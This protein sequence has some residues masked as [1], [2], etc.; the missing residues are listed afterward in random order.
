MRHRDDRHVDAGEGA[1]L[2]REHAARVDH[3]P[4]LDRAPVGLDAGHLA[5]L[6]R[7]P[8]DARARVDLGAAA[9]RAL[10]EREGELARVDVA[11]AR[12]V[13]GA[14]DAVGRHR[15]EEL[16][17]L[18]RRDELERQAER[19]RP[20]GLARDLLQ[21]LGRGGEPQ[22]ADLA[23]AG[24]EADLRLERAVELDRAHHHPRQRERAAQLADEPGGVERRAARQVGPLD[25]DDVVPAEPRQPVEDRAAADATADHDRARARS[26]SST[27]VD[28]IT[29]RV[30]SAR[31]RSRA[32]STGGAVG[33]EADA[34]HEQ[35]RR[36]APD[37]ERADVGRP[38]LRQLEP[39]D[40][41]DGAQAEAGAHQV[42]QR[43]AEIHVLDVGEEANRATTTARPRAACRRRGADG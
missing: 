17:R 42:V 15:R 37:P 32:N 11:V 34:L 28:S 38:R 35:E 31:K 41:P 22:R 26:H 40:G 18:G 43:A 8:R 2:L 3:D 30:R 21:P 13:R 23:P 20:A 29:S 16:L 25:E 9:A 1:D 5:A 27:P 7:D 39:L 36:V 14:E 33:R 4:G 12:Q 24:L 10:G 6:D 19:L